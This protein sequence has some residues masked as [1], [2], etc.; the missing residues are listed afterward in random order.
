MGKLD[1]LTNFNQT[2][3]VML[4]GIGLSASLGMYMIHVISDDPST[5]NYGLARIALFLGP[6]LTVGF[7][8]RVLRYYGV[9]MQ[10]S[11]VIGSLLAITAIFSSIGLL[12]LSVAISFF[13]ELQYLYG[14][15][16]LSSLLFLE[17]ILAEQLSLRVDT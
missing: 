4:Y 15:I 8:G 6:V 16:G 9:Y 11:R 3:L 14:F 17:A 10:Y 12:G 5:A 13:W 7:G 2:A 1:E